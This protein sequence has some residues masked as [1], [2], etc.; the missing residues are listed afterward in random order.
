MSTYLFRP[1]EFFFIVSQLSGLCLDVSRAEPEAGTRI[2][3]W[4]LNEE[5]GKPNQLWYE[6]KRSYI[7]TKLNDMVMDANGTCVLVCLVPYK[8]ALLVHR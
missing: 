6:D 4:T 1:A 3:T 8:P 7:R 2:T 5:A